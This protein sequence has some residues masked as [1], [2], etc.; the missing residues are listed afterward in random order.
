MKKLTK[1]DVVFFF[2]GA[3]V[4]FLV[5]LAIDQ[6]NESRTVKGKLKDGFKSVK[7]EFKR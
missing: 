7:K 3:L 4:M 5:N 6:Y 2:L 1:R